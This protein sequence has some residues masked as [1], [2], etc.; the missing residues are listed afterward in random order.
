MTQV[1]EYVC[2]YAIPITLMMHYCLLVCSEDS[3]YQ[4][5]RLKKSIERIYKRIVSLNEYSHDGV[6]FHEV[7]VIYR[8]REFMV[9]LHKEEPN[10]RYTTYELFINGE[11]AGKLHIVGDCCTSAYY[12]EVLNKRDKCEVMSIIH[13]CAKEVN[14]LEK[15]TTEKKVSWNE[16]SYFN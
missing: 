10:N 5:R 16:H 12:F 15:S 2:L 13:A 14:K 1:F 7:K 3:K 11:A 6:R 9:G 4:K 8:N